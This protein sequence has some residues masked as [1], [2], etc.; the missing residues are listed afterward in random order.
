MVTNT[1][2]ATIRKKIKIEIL[3]IFVTSRAF[4]RKAAMKQRVLG[5]PISKRLLPLPGTKNRKEGVDKG[6]VSYLGVSNPP[7]K[8]SHPQIGP[9]AILSAEGAQHTTA[10]MKCTQPNY[11]PPSLMR[12]PP[13]CD[14]TAYW[15]MQKGQHTTALHL[16]QVYIWNLRCVPCTSTPTFSSLLL[17]Y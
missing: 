5:S 16:L 13:S 15:W 4:V 3:T 10:E 9:D 7:Q 11:L 8:C 17:V 1:L 2:A 14:M 6:D 12:S